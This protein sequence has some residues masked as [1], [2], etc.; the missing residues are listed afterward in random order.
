MMTVRVPV[1]AMAGFIAAACI[2]CMGVGHWSDPGA[3]EVDGYWVTNEM[4]CTAGEPFPCSFEIAAAQLLLPT[5]APVGARVMVALPPIMWVRPDGTQVPAAFGGL[6]RP[7]FVILDLA[8]GSRVAFLMLCDLAGDLAQPNCTH[9][10]G[11]DYRVGS[12]PRWAR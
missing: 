3:H 12:V 9:L 8:D 4:S 7:E 2:G 10:P 1:L 5:P 6:G 11:A